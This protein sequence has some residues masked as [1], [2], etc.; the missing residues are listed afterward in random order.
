MFPDVTGGRRPPTVVPLPPSGRAY[1]N[2]PPQVR[3]ELGFEPAPA[4]GMHRALCRAVDPEVFFPDPEAIEE[5]ALAE[6]V[7]LAKDFCGWCPAKTVCLV[8]ALAQEGSAQ[9]PDRY[10]IRGGAT[11]AERYGMYRRRLRAAAK[12][13]SLARQLEEAA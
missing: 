3:D 6:A 5:G 4:P 9:T 12:A 10:G 7:A 13:K 1:R 2:V 8:T 11:P